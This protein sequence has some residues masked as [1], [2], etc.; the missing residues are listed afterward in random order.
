MVN[1]NILQRH[2]S[3]CIC[4]GFIKRENDTLKNNAVT[5]TLSIIGFNEQI[6]D[7]I[8]IY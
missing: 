1:N 6:D 7:R 4:A 3:A 5:K 8:I 2:K